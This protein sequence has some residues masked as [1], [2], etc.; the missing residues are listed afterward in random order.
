VSAGWQ[1]GTPWSKVLSLVLMPPMYGQKA[2]RVTINAPLD[3]TRVEQRAAQLRGLSWV[4]LM[5]LPPKPGAPAWSREALEAWRRVVS[6]R[7]SGGSEATGTTP[8]T[9]NGKGGTAHESALDAPIEIVDSLGIGDGPAAP[10]RKSA[11]PG[12]RRRS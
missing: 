2:T 10:G 1:F 6:E 8:S 5:Q 3:E 4:E 9:A 7:K 11:G 12:D